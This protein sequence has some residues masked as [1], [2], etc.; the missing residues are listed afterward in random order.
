[1]GKFI[2][3]G[4]YNKLYK[5]VW[6]YILISLVNQYFF[7]N[8][9]PD[10]FK[11][12]LLKS[13]NFP[14][15]IFI[16]E[17]FNHIGTLI[18][19]LILFKYETFQNKK[20]NDKPSK[21]ILATQKKTLIYNDYEKLSIANFKLYIQV[22]ILI[23]ICNELIVILYVIGL[24]EFEYWTFEILFISLISTIMFKKEIYMH[25]KISIILL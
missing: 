1:M 3:C 7:E 15:S 16:Q 22:I 12:D 9:F 13:T 25:Q 21:S 11:F 8:T 5:Y 6:I 4:K 14:S 18:C 23:V 10:E 2:K 24:N 19:S 17:L 20:E